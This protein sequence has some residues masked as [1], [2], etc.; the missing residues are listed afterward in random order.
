MAQTQGWKI[1]LHP[2][3]ISVGKIYSFE[4]RQDRPLGSSM[5]NFRWHEVSMKLPF[6]AFRA[7]PSSHV[8]FQLGGRIMLL[9]GYPTIV[10]CC[11]LLRQRYKFKVGLILILRPLL[12]DFQVYNVFMRIISAGDTNVSLWCIVRR[13][14]P[15]Q[16]GR[17][18]CTKI[19]E[20]DDTQRETSELINTVLQQIDIGC[21]DLRL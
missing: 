3:D 1:L 15:T 21:W 18:C 8:E 5:V 12:W 7:S 9:P 19:K 6:K 16:S 17:C 20:I 11:R 13:R 4:V 14:I 2:A 10:R